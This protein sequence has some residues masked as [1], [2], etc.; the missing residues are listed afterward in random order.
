MIVS[1][2]LVS[3]DFAQEHI[4]NHDSVLAGLMTYIPFSEGP[5]EYAPLDPRFSEIRIVY[6]TAQHTALGNLKGVPQCWLQPATL[7]TKPRYTA[8]SYTWGD[9]ANQR[10]ILLNGKRFLV[11]KN[12]LSFLHQEAQDLRDQHISRRGYWIDA[13]CI[14]QNDPDEKGWQ[15]GMMGRIYQ[16]ATSLDIW[17]GPA[18][19]NTHH[20]FKLLEQLALDQTLLDYERSGTLKKRVALGTIVRIKSMSESEDTTITPLVELVSHRWW[21]RV[22]I[23]QEVSFA[24]I[25]RSRLKCGKLHVPWKIVIKAHDA[26]G[27]IVRHSREVPVHLGKRSIAHPRTAVVISKMTWCWARM[28]Q[29]CTNN[30]SHV[31]PARQAHPQLALS[32]R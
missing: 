3:N 26:M 32:N 23:Q 24:N 4:E 7:D 9:E 17:F 12:L 30:Y 25:K 27:S 18:N 31:F 21:R 15:I 13:I 19:D 2:C 6:I 14:N 29:T 28:R 1:I 11:R 20:A 5:F 8:L 16:Q 10:P 22:W